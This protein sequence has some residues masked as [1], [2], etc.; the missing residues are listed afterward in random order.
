MANIDTGSSS[1]ITFDR[2]MTATTGSV[3][4]TGVGFNPRIVIILALVAGS[5]C[6]SIGFSLATQDRVIYSNA[7]GVSGYFAVGQAV[8]CINTGG[9]GYLQQVGT[10]SSRGADGFT[11]SWTK[12]GSP[13]SGT[14]NCY[15]LCLR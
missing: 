14:A 2:D 7:N 8:V 10:I 9:G 4:Y 1:Y 15:A 6:M 11:M 5:P 13:G 12:N 3:A